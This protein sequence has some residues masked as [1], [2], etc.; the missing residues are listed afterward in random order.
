MGSEENT[1][2]L[3]ILWHPAS[4]IAWD[5]LFLPHSDVGSRERSATEQVAYILNIREPFQ[6]PTARIRAD[7]V[8]K[9]YK[10]WS[11]VDVMNSATY[12]HKHSKNC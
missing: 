4:I 12:Q 6:W 11:S 9:K 1:L 8:L 10:I 5:Y 2:L 3:L 7:T